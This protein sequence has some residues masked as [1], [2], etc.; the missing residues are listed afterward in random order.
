M[1]LVKAKCPNCGGSLSIDDSKRAAVCPWCHEAYVVQD[2]INNI[3]N[4]NNIR[5]DVVNIYG[6]TAKDFVIRGGKLEKY[7]SSSPKVVIPNTVSVIGEKAFENCSA[8]TSVEIPDSVEEIEPDAFS[9][10]SRLK[11][12]DFPS[13]LIKISGFTGC[14]GLSD[15]TIPNGVT[16][17]GR[18]AF[19]KCSGLTHITIPKGVDKIESHAFSGCSSLKR[20]SIP[21]NTFIE[22]LAFH[23]TKIEELVLGDVEI[24]EECYGDHLSPIGTFFDSFNSLKNVQAPPELLRKFVR[25]C[26]YINKEA[27]I[28]V[29]TDVKKELD[30]LNMQLKALGLFGAK[31]QKNRLKWKISELSDELSQLEQR[32]RNA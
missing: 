14:T 20:V 2:A 11:M 9:D 5:T 1:P 8:L 31:D 21:G 3:Y 19:Y 16:V 32:I 10:C 28:S 23:D 29:R 27:L 4:T 25:E 26:L 22:A 13:S 7:N 18:S 24:K 12:V 17:I 6:D 30:E 15:I